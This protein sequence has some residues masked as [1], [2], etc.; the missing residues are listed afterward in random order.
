MHW[1]PETVDEHQRRIARVTERLV[2]DLALPV[3]S[4]WPCRDGIRR[5]RP[6][7][8]DELDPVILFT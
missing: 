2:V 6:R 4:R 3:A 1:L 5:T 7:F 8:A